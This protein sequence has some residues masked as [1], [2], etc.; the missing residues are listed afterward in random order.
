MD[1]T[2]SSM[3]GISGDS[4]FV[5]E[6]RFIFPSFVSD[7]WIDWIVAIKPLTVKMEIAAHRHTYRLSPLFP[8][9][10]ILKTSQ[11][12]YVK[13]RNEIALNAGCKFR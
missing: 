10:F 12:G 9:L 5:M 7:A 11:Y 2:A 13:L 1:G 8:L 3:G 4:I 6:A